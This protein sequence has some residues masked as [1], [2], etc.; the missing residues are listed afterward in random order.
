MVIEPIYTKTKLALH[1]FVN[2]CRA[3]PRENPTNRQVTD[4]QM[5]WSLHKASVFYFVMN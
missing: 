5:M 4:G 3:D 1:L 2:E